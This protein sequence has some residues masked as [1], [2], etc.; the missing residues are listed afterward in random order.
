MTGV[1]QCP[2]RANDDL[3]G[4]RYEA[5]V[6]KYRGVQ[7]IDKCLEEDDDIDGYFVRGTHHL[8]GHL[9]IYDTDLDNFPYILV[10][11]GDRTYH[12]KGWIYGREGK[13]V[14]RGSPY[15][16]SGRHQRHLLKHD[17]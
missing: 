15:G 7:Y 11:G 10:V 14:S 1:V 3:E 9:I 13:Q 5:A 4:S 2:T 8:D 12:L 6:A 16:R 17:A